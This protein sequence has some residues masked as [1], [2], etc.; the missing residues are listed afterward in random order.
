MS[1]E[2]ILCLQ[3]PVESRRYDSSCKSGLL[4]SSA[5][6][7]WPPNNLLAQDDGSVVFCLHFFVPSSSLL[8]IL[9]QLVLHECI[10][11]RMLLLEVFLK[12]W[13]EALFDVIG[14]HI[15]LERLERNSHHLHDPFL[16]DFFFVIWE[17]EVHFHLS[18]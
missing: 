12:V 14:V 3:W 6:L 15:F 2:V 5:I 1:I 18:S 8:A 9:R 16:Q 7:E 17:I 11:I 10:P 4:P 13:R